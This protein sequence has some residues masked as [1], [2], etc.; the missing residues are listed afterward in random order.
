MKTSTGQIESEKHCT[1]C[2]LRD[3]LLAINVVYQRAN[4]NHRKPEK[5]KKN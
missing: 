3:H 4:L 1:H 2:G 5:D